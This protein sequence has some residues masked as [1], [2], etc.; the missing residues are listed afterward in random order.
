M[1]TIIMK[2]VKVL[3]DVVKQSMIKKDN[4]NKIKIE[5]EQDPVIIVNIL[6]FTKAHIVI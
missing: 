2:M 1:N 4:K 5:D 6:T 3:V